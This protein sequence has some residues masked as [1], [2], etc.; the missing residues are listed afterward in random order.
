MIITALA[1]AFL[2]LLVFAAYFGR[3]ALLQKPA[4]PDDVFSEKCS[5]CREKFHKSKL[6][7]RQIGDY[8]MLYFCKPCI[9][10][11]NSDSTRIGT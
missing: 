6:I 11:L 7:E 2:I 9:E 5:I 8:K 4:N 10:K 3:M 1:V